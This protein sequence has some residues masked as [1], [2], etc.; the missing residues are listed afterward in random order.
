MALTTFRIKV[1]GEWYSIQI[2]DI[3]QPAVEVTVNGE[4]FLVEI[5]PELLHR[6]TRRPPHRRQSETNPDQSPQSDDD[7]LKI[8]RSPMPGKVM[9]ISVRP[10]ESVM[11]GQEL[12]RRGYE[13]GTEHLLTDR[14][15]YQNNPCP[16]FG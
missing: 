6:N 3:T 11:S 2:G 7:S 1:G 9:S 15:H 14:R 10:G 5:D 16:T 8:L 12:C 13:N 4:S